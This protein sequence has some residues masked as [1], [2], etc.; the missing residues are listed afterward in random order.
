[1]VIKTE[2]CIYSEWKI[3]P[4]RGQKF[5]AKDGRS[6]LFLSKKSRVLGLK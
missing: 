6:S 4:G 3:Y 2:L 5:V 1:M